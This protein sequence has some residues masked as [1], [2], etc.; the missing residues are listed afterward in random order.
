MIDAHHKA[1]NSFLEQEFSWLKQIINLRFESFFDPEFEDQSIENIQPPKIGED[2]AY[3]RFL[4]THNLGLSERIVIGIALAS[5]LKPELFNLFHIENKVTGKNYSEFGGAMNDNKFTPT[6]RTA[7]FILNDKPQALPTAIYELFEQAH[8]FTSEGIMNFST[9]NFQNRLDTPI[10]LS[11]ETEYLVLTGLL[12]KSEFNADFPAQEIETALNWEDLVISDQVNQELKEPLNWFKYEE[13]LSNDAHYSKWITKGYR[14]LFYGPS[15]TGKTLTASLL[16][17]TVNRPVYRVDLSM[18]VSKYIGE[19]IKN[20]EKVFFRAERNKWILFFDEADAIFG[21]RTTTSSSNDRHANQEVAYL[22]Q[23]IENF[24][25]LIILASNLKNNIDEA[26]SRRFQSI[27]HFELPDVESRIKLWNKIFESTGL[28]KDFLKDVA[29]K[30]EL[31]GGSL[32]NVLQTARI[33]SD[34]NEAALTERAVLF[35]IRKEVK[36]GGKRHF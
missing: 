22:L 31:T 13:M 8:P 18:V 2:S 25:G 15:G 4:S 34:I 35:A 10:K 19:T 11:L 12:Y 27:I 32:I 16:G 1:I 21:A 17:K 29:E 20:L 6:Y 14:V 36:K 26:F 30:Y 33:S 24:P 5:T 23:R 9:S 3:E 28:S 7:A